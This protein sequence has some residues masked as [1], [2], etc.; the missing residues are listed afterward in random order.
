MRSVRLA[1]LSCALL[2]SIALSSA[3][4]SAAVVISTAATQN[5]NCSGGLCAPTAKNAV[6][7]VGDLTSMLAS[8]DVEVSTGAGLL[9]AKVEDI[10]VDAGFNWRSATGLTLD[11]WRSVAFENGA[12]VDSGNGA[13]SLVTNDGGGDGALSFRPGASLAFASTNNSLTINGARF[14]L[15]NS[16]ATLANAIAAAP[17][18]RF[19]LANNY[20]AAQDGKYHASP[21]DTVLLGTVEGLGNTISNLSIA[22]VQTV[23]Q[24]TGL[25]LR[26]R[27][28]CDRIGPDARE[29]KISRFGLELSGWRPCRPERR[30][31]DKRLCKRIHHRGRR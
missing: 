2:A 11:A 3:P 8:G 24:S 21:I 20:D 18:G 15:E 7:N 22:H 6:L 29:Y 25:V 16:I 1:A 26:D 23:T 30:H 9:A 19:A 12:V 31:R 14:A 17:D 27:R 10:V 4:V 13:V 5:M 28:N